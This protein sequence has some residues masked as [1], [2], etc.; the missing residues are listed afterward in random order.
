L[1]FP[2]EATRLSA[3][4]E[5]SLLER[6]CVSILHTRYELLSLFPSLC[7]QGFPPFLI[8]ATFSEV[9]NNQMRCSLDSGPAGHLIT[10]CTSSLVSVVGSD[11]SALRGFRCD[12]RLWP[13]ANWRARVAS[14]RG[15]QR[16]TGR[17]ILG[18][19]QSRSSQERSLFGFSRARHLT[20]TAA[21]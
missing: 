6:F 15:C 4:L 21:T 19:S 7:C 5:S 12:G 16:L 20:N 9:S 13:R 17:G 2:L 8:L 3:V 14:A 10:P 1:P 18:L 11:I